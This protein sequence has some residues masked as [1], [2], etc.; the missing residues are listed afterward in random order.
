MPSVCKL[1]GAVGEHRLGGGSAFVITADG[2]IVTNDH[3]FT[4]IRGA[5]AQ[6][7]HAIFDDG[8]AFRVEHIASDAEADI[9]V[10]RLLAPA[11]TRFAPLR[12][13]ASGALRRGDLVCVLGA[14][15]GGSLVP[16]TGT[17]SG[18]RYVADDEVMNQ[19]LNSRA[20]WCLLQVDAAMASGSSGGPIVNA[21]G[22]VVGVSVMVQ[23]AAG[24]GGVGF[25]NFGVA[26]DQAEPIIRALVA[27]G[28]VRRAAIG[29]TIVAVD[30]LAAEREAAASGV[31]LLPRGG[32]HATGLLVTFVAPG[33][34][35]AA[36]GLRE[37][38]V[39]LEV[40]GRPLTRKGDYFAAL[41]PV[42]APG[43][44]LECKVFRPAAPP[45]PPAVAGTRPAPGLGG[46]VLTVTI[47][48]TVREEVVPVTVRGWLRRARAS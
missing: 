34:P 44:A 5:G 47:V 22:D 46:D 19:V 16:T 1:Q 25:V 26:I 8:R 45:A 3:V 33:K 21:D 10:G 24:G 12:L 37:G 30:A 38:D 15:L 4:A 6:E 18:V 35:A 14:P 7:I 28:A 43:H 36:A 39:L 11:G 29:M 27:R 32:G 20:D 48:P 9:A 17:L 2:L 31:A 13:G 40:N 42:Y 23:A 41:G